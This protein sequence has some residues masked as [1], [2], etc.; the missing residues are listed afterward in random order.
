MVYTKSFGHFKLESEAIVIINKEFEDVNNWLD[1]LLKINNLKYTYFDN[2]D[3]LINGCQNLMYEL[4]QLVIVLIRAEESR[5]ARTISNPNIEHINSYF[6][7]MDF[8]NSRS[9][10]PDKL[11]LLIDNINRLNELINIDSNIGLLCKMRVCK[12]DE[13]QGIFVGD[14]EKFK[15]ILEQELICNVRCAFGKFNICDKE[16][17]ILNIEDSIYD[18]PFDLLGKVTWSTR[19]TLN[20]NPTLI[21]VKKPVPSI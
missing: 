7:M 19:E 15:K 5:I 6:F 9:F 11:N 12:Q 21:K 4:M 1:M 13:I 8:V 3:P 20:N 14:L 18:S 10:Y 17:G 2:Y 16:K